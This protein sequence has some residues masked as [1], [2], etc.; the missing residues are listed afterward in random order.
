[1]DHFFLIIHTCRQQN[2][3]RV[4]LGSVQAHEFVSIHFRHHHV[5]DDQ[6]RLFPAR[7]LE[8]L[9]AI[10]CRDYTVPLLGDV[11]V[12]QG[13]QSFFIVHDHNCS[14]HETSLCLVEV[15]CHCRQV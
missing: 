14:C 1:S 12:N 15:R 4:M 8:R 13:D 3:R 9:P 10:I 7:D 5:Q 11:V 6:V 2:D